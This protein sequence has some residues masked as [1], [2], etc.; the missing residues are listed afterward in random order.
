MYAVSAFRVYLRVVSPSLQPDEI[1]RRLGIDPDESM[2]VGSQRRPELP[3][4][5]HTTWIRRAE[6]S[7]VDARPEHVEPVILD[8]GQDFACALGK[9][10]ES[11]DAAV[12]LVIIQEI[13]DIDNEMEKGIFLGAQLISWLS[14]ANASLDID[15][16]IYHD[17]D[18]RLDDPESPNVVKNY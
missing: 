12:S 4:R 16:Y 7:R 10:A 13:N 9:L 18:D 14:T 11:S 2:A 15:Q 5:P 3:P 8:W 1:S 17:C 6:T